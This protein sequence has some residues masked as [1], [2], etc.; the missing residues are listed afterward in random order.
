[1]EDTMQQRLEV[2]EI[3][4]EPDVQ[5]IR[6]SSNKNKPIT[7]YHRLSEKYRVANRYKNI[8]IGIVTALVMWYND[9]ICVESI[10]LR[11]LYAGGIVLVMSFLCGAVDEI[12]MEE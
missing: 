9:W 10:P 12:L 8:M 6:S 7:D 1:M 11:L 2:R 3:K 5:N 4:E